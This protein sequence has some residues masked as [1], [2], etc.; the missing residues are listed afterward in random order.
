MIF[1]AIDNIWVWSS[2][3]TYRKCLFWYENST[4]YQY[5]VKKPN[6]KG[7]KWNPVNWIPSF[8][9]IIIKEGLLKQWNMIRIYI[10]ANLENRGE[11]KIEKYEAIQLYY[12]LAL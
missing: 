7:L 1:H 8:K 2:V 12:D 4:K 6:N 11:I 9:I 10:N 5:L 3:T